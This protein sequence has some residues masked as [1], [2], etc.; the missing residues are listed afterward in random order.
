MCFSCSFWNGCI[1]LAGSFN[2]PHYFFLVPFQ[3][4]LSSDRPT[5][6]HLCMEFLFCSKRISL[7]PNWSDTILPIILFVNQSIPHWQQPTSFLPSI[8]G[9]A[10]GRR[11]TRKEE[12]RRGGGRGKRKEERKWEWGQNEGVNSI[13]YTFFCHTILL[14]QQPSHTN[15]T[16]AT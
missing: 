1:D 3:L 10:R 2:L 9:L 15:D 8:G 12:V 13:C 7:Q 5:Y 6:S 14:Q 16:I 4:S 11:G